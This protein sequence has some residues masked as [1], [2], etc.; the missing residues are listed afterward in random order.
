MKLLSIALFLLC[1]FVNAQ[2]WHKD[3]LKFSKPSV[4]NNGSEIIYQQV[5][6]NAKTKVISGFTGSPIWE[7]DP[8]VYDVNAAEVASAGSNQVKATLSLE[9]DTQTSIRTLRLRVFGTSS[10]PLFSKDLASDPLVMNNRIG[11]HVSRNGLK[12]L[13][14]W[15]DD[16]FKKIQIRVFDS[17]TGQQTKSYTYDWLQFMFAPA[18]SLVDDNL[19]YIF[20][21]YPLVIDLE[22]GQEVFNNNIFGWN[23]NIRISSRNGTTL[24]G[25]R[26][27]YPTTEVLVLKN[28][29]NGFQLL[30]TKYFTGDANNV[31]EVEL[32]PNGKYLAVATKSYVSSG[33]MKVNI[34]D[35]GLPNQDLIY[36]SN[37]FPQAQIESGVTSM[38]FETENKLLCA[39]TKSSLYSEMFSFTKVDNSWSLSIIGEHELV[40]TP[41]QAIVGSGSTNA[42]FDYFTGNINGT[43]VGLSRIVSF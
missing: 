18:S 32:S 31:S 11:V 37:T 42:L 24:I 29:G 20:F 40:S 26:Y 14:W 9:R 21:N 39:A 10:M 19:K 41:W 35:L 7:Y 43:R 33:G 8:N 36:T 6:L 3:D 15:A 17:F 22:T 27:P 28:A 13:A 5:G 16:T 2:T 23:G 12:T 1:P 4:G 25:L 38:R 30:T 34:Y